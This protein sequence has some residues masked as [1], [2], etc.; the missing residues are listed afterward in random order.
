MDLKLCEAKVYPKVRHQAHKWEIV[1]VYKGWFF[2]WSALKNDEVSD[3]IINP[4][5]KVLSARIS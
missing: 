1:V 5:K 3:Y 4:I 2:G